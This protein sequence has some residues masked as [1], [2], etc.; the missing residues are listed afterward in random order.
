MIAGEADNGQPVAKKIATASG[1][2][3]YN[4]L[5][6]N[7]RLAH[8]VVDHVCLCPYRQSPDDDTSFP[9]PFPCGMNLRT[10]FSWSNADLLQI[11]KPNEEEGLGIGW[12]AQETDMEKLKALHSEIKAKM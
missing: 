12:P 11:P 4:L 7:G 6:N 3:N 9:G 2:E 10:S 8:Q 5:Q 1:L